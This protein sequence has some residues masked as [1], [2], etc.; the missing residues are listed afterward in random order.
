MAAISYWKCECGIEWKAILSEGLGETSVCFCKRPHDLKG[1][2]VKL[3]YTT[4]EGDLF[5]WD[6]KEVHRLRQ[7]AVAALEEVHTPV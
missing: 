6:C 2:L 7:V 5:S 3:T 4:R 1:T